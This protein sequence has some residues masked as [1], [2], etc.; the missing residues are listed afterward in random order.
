MRLQDCPELRRSSNNW[1]VSLFVPMLTLQS[2]SN[3]TTLNCVATGP[4]VLAGSNYAVTNATGSM[5]NF[6]RLIK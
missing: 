4:A 5:A 3:L 2:N 6:Y 1:S